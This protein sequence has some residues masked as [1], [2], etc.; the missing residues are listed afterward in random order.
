MHQN[1]S[2]LEGNQLQSANF[3]SNERTDNHPCN[4]YNENNYDNSVSCITVS[5][6]NV[7]DNFKV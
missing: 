1:S 5:L 6:H 7:L 4:F 2:Q 3:M